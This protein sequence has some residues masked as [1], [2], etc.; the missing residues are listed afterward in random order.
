MLEE[1]RG[2]GMFETPAPKKKFTSGKAISLLA[3]AAFIYL[4]IVPPKAMVV[5][6]MQT[7]RGDRGSGRN[8]IFMPDIASV[9]GTA[10]KVPKNVAK[11]TFNKNPRLVEPARKPKTEALDLTRVPPKKAPDAHM[12]TELGLF[13]WGM[14]HGHDVRPALPVVS[15]NPP[16]SLPSG[17]TGDVIVEVTI[18]RNGQVVATKLLVGLNPTINDT[19]L[20]TLQNWHF[21]PAT[22]DGQPIASQ[23]D[24]HFHF[25]T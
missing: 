11:N 20:A 16:I 23:H 12:G 15:P 7:M 24:V 14:V 5:L 4:L 13:A 8:S 1:H 22:L 3:H 9:T 18:D 6:P 25:P 10:K 17:M 2:W 19:I 21:T